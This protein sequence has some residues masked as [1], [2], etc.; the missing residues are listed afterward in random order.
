VTDDDGRFQLVQLMA[1]DPALVNEDLNEYARRRWVAR[2]LT[3]VHDADP[4]HGSW[5]VLLEREQG[6]HS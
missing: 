4:R 6:G 1:V 2:S 3:W 5:W